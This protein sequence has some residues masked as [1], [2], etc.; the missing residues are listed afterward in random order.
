MPIAILGTGS[1]GSALGIAFA[2]VGHAIVY[3][4]RTPDAD[5]VQQLVARTANGAATTHAAAVADADVVVLATP[6]EA[7]E[8]LVRSLDLAG[9]VVLDAT[10]PLS[11]PDLGLVLETSAGE[12]VQE[13]APEA[14]VVKAFSTVGANIMAD[15]TFA[16]D[17][18]PAMFVAG[19]DADAKAV[20]I[21]L[22]EALG[23][24]GIDAGPISR[25]RALEQM[26]VLWIHTAVHGGRE[27]ALGL[28]RR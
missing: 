10:N 23:F 20:A 7:T 15:A 19:D 1:V 18:R 17:V 27:M 14:H 5:E 22:S 9:K 11:W 24:E 12:V 16:G 25:S 3:G 21:E 13:A 26:A 4:S 28:L 2:N 8:A 6:W